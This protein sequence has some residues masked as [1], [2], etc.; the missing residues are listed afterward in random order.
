MEYWAAVKTKEILPFATAWVDLESIVLSE[1]IQSAEDVHI[2]YVLTYM[3]NLINKI[4]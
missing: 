1:I 3:W 4:N 2:P